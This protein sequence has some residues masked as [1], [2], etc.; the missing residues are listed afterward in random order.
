MLKT[1]CL[2]NWLSTIKYILLGNCWTVEGKLDWIAWNPYEWTAWPRQP[3]MFVLGAYRKKPLSEAIR[4]YLLVVLF[5]WWCKRKRFPT[6][7]RYTPDSLN[8]REW[9][10]QHEAEKRKKYGKPG[11]R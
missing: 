6:R 4:L 1:E 10:K 5:R 3:F 7:I 2:M 8:Y 11:R 9:L